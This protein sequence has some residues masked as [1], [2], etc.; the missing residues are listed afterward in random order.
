M[1][2]FLIPDQ[3]RLGRSDFVTTSGLKTISVRVHGTLR[4]EK[5]RKHRFL[6]LPSQ[7]IE[8][9]SSDEKE[10]NVPA[11]YL[12]DTGN[13]IVRTTFSGVVTCQELVDCATRLRSDPVFYPALSE[14]VTFEG[15]PDVRLGYLDWL[16]LAERE[17]WSL[18]SKHAFVL[19]SRG[20]LFGV[21]RMCQIARNDTTNIRIFDTEAEALIWLS[22]PAGIAL[23][24]S[25]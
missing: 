3:S 10:Q 8:E 12:I 19:P 18:H 23:A 14:L 21:V 6:P 7:A 22:M 2:P 25:G 24:E 4:L 17:P 9:T 13:H 20:V 5:I 1:A 11:Q 15:N 16:S